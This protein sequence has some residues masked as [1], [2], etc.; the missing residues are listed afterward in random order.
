MESEDLIQMKGEFKKAIF[1]LIFEESERN[2]WNVF[3]QEAA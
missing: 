3:L 1:F 2:C